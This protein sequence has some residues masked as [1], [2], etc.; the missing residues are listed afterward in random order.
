MAITRK[1]VRT[2]SPYEERESF[3]RAVVVGDWVYV[4]Q[5]AGIDYDSQVLP[6]TVEGQTNLSLDNLTRAL[7]A[8]G[9]TLADVVRRQ[10]MIPNVE[11]AEEVMRIVGERFKGLKPANVV[12]CT[13]LGAPQYLVEIEV[14]AYRGIG[15]VEAETVTV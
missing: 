4:S 14:T 6:D 3:A 9:A 12:F 2:S 11:H 7:E 15:A 10:V 13:P 5:C 8:A 1:L